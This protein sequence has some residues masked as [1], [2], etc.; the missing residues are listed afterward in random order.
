MLGFIIKQD[1][2]ISKHLLD[3]R[4]SWF[5][6]HGS[7]ATYHIAYRKTVHSVL[8]ANLSQQVPAPKPSAEL[9]IAGQMQ[10]QEPSPKLA[11][12]PTRDRR[13]T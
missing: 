7:Y 13:R 9:K 12:P 6:I 4:T 5:E 3:V 2:L 1:Y 11:R 8:L 10:V